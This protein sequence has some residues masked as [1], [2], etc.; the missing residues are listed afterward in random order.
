M[1]K[2]GQLTGLRY[3]FKVVDYLPRQAVFECVITDLPMVEIFYVP[4]GILLDGIKLDK[5]YLPPQVEKKEQFDAQTKRLFYYHE[6]KESVYCNI[7]LDKDFPENGIIRWKA[8]D[9]PHTVILREVSSNYTFSDI[10]EAEQLIG[11]YQMG[12][13]ISGPIAGLILKNIVTKK[14]VSVQLI[15]GGT[16]LIS[17]TVY[18]TIL[19]DEIWYVTVPANIVKT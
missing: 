13:M 4:V 19:V 3:D 16:E 10:P 7:E 6:I 8:V 9:P 18:I 14:S 12:Q 17:N 15:R 2:V 11:M 1:I 5:Y